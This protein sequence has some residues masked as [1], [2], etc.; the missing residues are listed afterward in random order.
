VLLLYWVGLTFSRAVLM[1]GSGG[2]P[3][4]ANNRRN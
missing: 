3:I 2:V 4:A 1:E